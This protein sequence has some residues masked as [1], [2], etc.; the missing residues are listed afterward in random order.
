MSKRRSYIFAGLLS[1]ASSTFLIA[2][3]QRE[4]V[5][6]IFGKPVYVIRDVVILPL[7]SQKE[8]EHAIT[9]ALA[10]RES[11]TTGN[12]SDSDFSEP[13]EEDESPPKEVEPETPIEHPLTQQKNS[14]STSIVRDV[15]A[16][17]GQY[18]RF[19]S[20][21]F[22][23]Q[24]WR[25]AKA[26]TPNSSAPPQQAQSSSTAS[27]T[28]EGHAAAAANSPKPQGEGG[29][30]KQTDEAAHIVSSNSIR[31]ALPR[32]IK[33]TRMIL[34][35]GSYFFSYD[36]DLTRRLVLLGGNAKAPARETLDPLVRC[37]IS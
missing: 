3:T 27:S 6:Q 20:Q 9:S 2:I 24:G 11:S 15:I 17:R 8:A 30:E 31:D 5:A 34:T 18:A 33:T 36:F 35:S 13:G 22:S 26:G 25:G 37:G 10:S 32:I 16:N 21:W 29:E 28:A 12:D 14:S 4:Q 1:I 7:S 23:K 19:A